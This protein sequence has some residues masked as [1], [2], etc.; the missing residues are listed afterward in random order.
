[1]RLGPQLAA[2]GFLCRRKWFLARQENKIVTTI[3]FNAAMPLQSAKVQHFDP[4]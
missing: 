1:M 4:V 3:L 2:I